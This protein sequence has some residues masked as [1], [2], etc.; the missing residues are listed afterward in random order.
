MCETIK[1][2]AKSIGQ[3]IA[4]LILGALIAV[5]I[6]I[7]FD[8]IEIH[9]LNY[10]YVTDKY[11]DDGHYWYSTI[12]YGN[13]SITRRRGGEEKYYITVEYEGETDYWTISEEEWNELSVGDYIRR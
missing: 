2:A 1:K 3:F 6:V 12:S 7:G 11:M 9:K 8:R 13:Y 5:A 10:G 4:F